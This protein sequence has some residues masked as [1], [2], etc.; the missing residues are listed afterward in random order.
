MKR[1]SVEQRKCQ[2][3]SMNHV[4]NTENNYVCMEPLIDDI[5]GKIIII[6]ETG[7]SYSDSDKKN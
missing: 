6:S 5:L 3:S 4:V 1:S 2:A 7:D